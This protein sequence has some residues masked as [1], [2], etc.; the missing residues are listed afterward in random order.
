MQ[1]FDKQMMKSITPYVVFFACVVFGVACY[2]QGLNGPWL[3]DDVPHL[4]PLVQ[5]EL[6][7]D[8]WHEFI[9]NKSGPFKRPVAM[10]SFIMN[11]F[12]NGGN[13][14]WWKFTNLVV[15]IL[16]GISIF[17]LTASL[18]SA[19]EKK[20]NTDS[21][22]YGAMI[23]GIW[24]LHPL[25]V[26]TVLYTVQRMT[27][28]SALFVFI[29]L[30]FYVAGRKRQIAGKPGDTFLLLSII[31]F[32]PLGIFSKENA[33]LMP[34]YM[35]LIEIFLFQFKSSENSI[36]SARALKIIL[37]LPMLLGVMA[38]SVFFNELVLEKYVIR[39]FT[40]YQRLITEF[41]ILVAYLFMI[42]VPMQRNMG[43]VHDDIVVS[44]HL[45]SPPSTF[46]SL[47]GIL[48]LLILAWYMRRRFSLAAFGIFFFFVSHLIESTIFPLELMFEHRNYIASYGMILVF[49]A[50]LREIKLHKHALS[51][52]TAGILAILGFSTYLQANTW[53]SA[54]SLND[55]VYKVHPKSRRIVAYKADDLANKG[56]YD[57]ARQLL[58]EFNG[59]GVF[60]QNLNISC[61]EY[62]F[63]NDNQFTNKDMNDWKVLDIYAINEIKELSLYGLQGKC[64]FSSGIFL[65]VLDTVL[66]YPLQDRF[67]GHKLFVYK[68]HY[69]WQD[70]RQEEAYVSLEQATRIMPQDPVPLFL[71]SQWSAESGNVVHAEEYYQRAVAIA[72]M[73]NELH[74]KLAASLR[75]LIENR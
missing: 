26:S 29:G 47:M 41:R 58:S 52:V 66:S 73:K 63:I 53:S 27:Q 50:L 2:W 72:D 18:F 23:A 16:T 21:W 55:Y 75:Q 62:G 7:T 1:S 30:L 28:L 32:T 64:R 5:S 40:V 59:P 51:I 54:E 12:I 38:I 4:L 10:A 17:A 37:L 15:H 56:Q 70:R 14:W 42:I 68:A 36:I 43:L 48:L 46:T 25:H 45:F 33:L 65:S 74:S 49:V 24:L 6:N 69:L 61:Q 35:L 57:Q 9:L 60:F 3:F 20:I 11:A 13:L 67:E 8:N 31:L 34:F 44:S 71:A 19:N 39:E 22:L